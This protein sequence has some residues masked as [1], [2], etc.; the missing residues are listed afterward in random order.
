[1]L[2]F[3]TPT[4]HKNFPQNVPCGLIPRVILCV[5][6][7]RELLADVIEDEAIEHK[8][9][10]ARAWGIPAD[11]WFYSN[12]ERILGGYVESELRKVNR[13]LSV[14]PDIALI[15]KRIDVVREFTQDQI[16]QRGQITYDSNFKTLN[17]SHHPFLNSLIADLNL[18]PDWRL[19]SSTGEANFFCFKKFKRIYKR[20]DVYQLENV[21]GFKCEFE[22]PEKDE[23]AIHLLMMWTP[24]EKQGLFCYTRHNFRIAFDLLCVRRGLHSLYSPVLGADWPECPLKAGK[25]EC[26]WR[27]KTVQL[28][29]RIGQTTRL[30]LYW[31][32]M[33]AMM[34]RWS[35]TNPE[36]L[37]FFSPDHA[38]EAKAT[39]EEEFGEN[40]Y[41]FLVRGIYDD[42][43]SAKLIACI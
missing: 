9:K 24:L 2:E 30:T 33:G 39:I 41:R 5:I 17:N 31:L 6:T 25:G 32:R 36:T 11:E 27:F 10:F 22:L 28:D 20:L 7:L 43:L 13:L 34:P 4:H 3:A 21:D 19:K 16:R 8:V 15:K 1:M 35:S 14:S 40:P 12:L 23:N 29:G 38:L 26:D 37:Y 42:A 18:Y